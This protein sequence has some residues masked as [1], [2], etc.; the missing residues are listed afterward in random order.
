MDNLTKEVHHYAQ[1]EM[2]RADKAFAW[3]RRIAF[4]LFGISLLFL[5]LGY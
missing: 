2:D 3:G 5:L 1:T 4:T